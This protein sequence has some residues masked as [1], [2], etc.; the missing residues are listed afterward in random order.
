MDSNLVVLM[1]GPSELI[2]GKYRSCPHMSV[3]TVQCAIANLRN[4]QTYKQEEVEPALHC[5]IKCGLRG[6]MKDLSFRD[7]FKSC[8]NSFVLRCSSPIELYCIRCNDYQYCSYLDKLTG[9]KRTIFGVS[10]PRKNS[11]KVNEGIGTQ[12]K[13]FLNMGATCFMN[14][15]L[16]VLCRSPLIQSE[17]LMRHFRDCAISNMGTFEAHLPSNI[18]N[19]DLHSCIPC[20]FKAVCEDLQ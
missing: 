15:V 9:R 14:S 4:F 10:D 5:C 17:Q 18:N 2:S 6:K 1:V 20:E 3:D 8:L 13:G 12:P 16:Q 19:S 7:H 11:N